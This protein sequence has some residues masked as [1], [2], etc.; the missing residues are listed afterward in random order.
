MH[1]KH[2]VAL[3]KH[4]SKLH[5][6]RCTMYPHNDIHKQVI[7]PSSQPMA[8]VR[9]SVGQTSSNNCIVVDFINNKSSPVVTDINQLTFA[10]AQNDIC[11]TVTEG[12]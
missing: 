6:L 4:L 2:L 7:P 5:H 8:G 10:Y 3:H 9:K 11:S 1:C 12:T